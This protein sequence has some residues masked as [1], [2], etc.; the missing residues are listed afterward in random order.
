MDK[1][2]KHWERIQ[3]KKKRE[4]EQIL[5]AIAKRDAWIMDATECLVR[6]FRR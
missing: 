1:A 2:Q 3:Q 4:A 6:Q 5:A